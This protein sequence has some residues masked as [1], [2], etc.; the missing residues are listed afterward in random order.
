MGETK[1]QLVLLGCDAA[2]DETLYCINKSYQLQHVE[3]C[4]KWLIKYKIHPQLTIM[5]GYYWQTHEQLNNTAA[6][7]KSLIISGLTRA[8]RVTLCKTLDCIACHQSEVYQ[9]ERA[10]N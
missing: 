9:R 7:M 5:V 1:I 6:E 3:N 4:L 2:A 10:A 8:L